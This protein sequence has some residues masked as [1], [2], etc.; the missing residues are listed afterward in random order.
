M[1]QLSPEQQEQLDLLNDRKRKLFAE[2][3][4]LRHILNDRQREHSSEMDRVFD[5]ID[6]VLDRISPRI[7]RAEADGDFAEADR[8]GKQRDQETLNDFELVTRSTYEFDN[9]EHKLDREKLGIFEEINQINMQIS[10][11]TG[12]SLAVVTSRDPHHF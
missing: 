8:L 4:E 2:R 7:M 11:L 6:Q 1:R 12:A 3:V 5:R 9:F 10:E